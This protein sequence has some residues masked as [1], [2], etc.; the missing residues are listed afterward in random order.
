MRGVR[1]GSDNP[2]TPSVASISGPV[3]GANNV[4]E[5]KRMDECL[6]IRMLKPKSV[7]R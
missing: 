5:I 7:T 6:F 4:S 3:H 1:G 2:T